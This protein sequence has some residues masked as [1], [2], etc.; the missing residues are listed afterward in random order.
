[1]S[2]KIIIIININIKYTFQKRCMLSH[3]AS[4]VGYFAVA[5]QVEDFAN[6]QDITPLSTIPVQFLVRVKRCSSCTCDQEPS[7]VSPTPKQNECFA[8]EVGD[9]FNVTLKATSQWPYV[10]NVFFLTLK[11]FHICKTTRGC[12]WGSFEHTF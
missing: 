5:L 1:M 12:S 6:P 10:L 11:F 8:R 7:F 9:Q 4:Q 2:N 3:N